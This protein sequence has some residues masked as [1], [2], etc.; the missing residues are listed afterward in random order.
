[1][2]HPCD[3][4]KLRQGSCHKFKGSIHYSEFHAEFSAH[5]TLFQ[6]HECLLNVMLYI[7]T[8]LYMMW[9]SSED[10]G[11]ECKQHSLCH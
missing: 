3:L 6:K 5:E 11:G 1:M 7:E 10:N 4:G 8:L 9:V 2:A